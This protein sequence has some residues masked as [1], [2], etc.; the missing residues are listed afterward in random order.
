MSKKRYQA[1]EARLLCYN[2]VMLVNHFDEK[3]YSVKI[4]TLV[5]HQ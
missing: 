3:T 4:S 2:Y 5:I 1:Q